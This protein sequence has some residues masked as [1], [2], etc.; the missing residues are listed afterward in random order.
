[1]EHPADGLLRSGTGQGR[2][3]EGLDDVQVTLIRLRVGRG[4]REVDLQRDMAKRGALSVKEFLGDGI[5]ACVV[6]LVKIANKK[7][8]LFNASIT[9]LQEEGK[10]VRCWTAVQSRVESSFDSAMIPLAVPFL[11]KSASL[12]LLINASCSTFPSLSSLTRYW[13][14]QS[15]KC[16]VKRHGRLA[17]PIIFS[18]ASASRLVSSGNSGPGRSG[19]CAGA[20]PEN[21]SY[22]RPRG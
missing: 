3:D 1:M 12:T 13:S 5:E 4:R 19:C 15:R 16:T 22:S 10:N 8:K 17:P 20:H 7:C 9:V 14:G 6:V 11:K 2:G 18:S 21:K